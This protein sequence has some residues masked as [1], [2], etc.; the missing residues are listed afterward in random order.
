MLET[1]D[2][3]SKS[4]LRRRML[5]LARIDGA[6]HDGQWVPAM[7]FLRARDDN[8]S[9]IANEAEA[10]E[11]LDSLLALGL[12][13]EAA[14]MDLSGPAAPARSAR[15]ASASRK[16]V[17]PC[18]ARRSR[19][20]RAWPTIDSETD[21][22]GEQPPAAK[23]TMPRSPDFF[24]NLTEQ[25]LEE[26]EEFARQPGRT[27]SE[28]HEWLKG[29]GVQ[30][31]E[32]SVYRWLQDFRLEDRTRRASEVARTYLD[33]AREADPAAIAEASLRP[34]VGGHDRVGGVHRRLR[35]VGGDGQRGRHVTD[36]EEVIGDEKISR[37]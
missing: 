20:S 10:G 5:N 36:G 22:C 6:R 2:E 9:P 37:W 24:R 28:V 13:E 8:A 4:E 33:A 3:Q 1:R 7:N 14:S 12:L 16:K 11:L 17:F 18:G 30:T 32:R 23:K 15:G 26:L 27:G 25:R 21:T 35:D 31:S 29:H 34:L 19:P